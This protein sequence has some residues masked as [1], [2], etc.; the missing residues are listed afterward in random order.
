MERTKMNLHAEVLSSTYKSLVGWLD[1]ST[2]KDNHLVFI[3]S[4]RGKS[5]YCAALL[6]ISH[7][8]MCASDG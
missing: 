2:F 3:K 7:F 6:S 5:F 1:I 8:K 4:F